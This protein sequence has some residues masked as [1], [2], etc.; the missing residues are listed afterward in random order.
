MIIKEE[1]NVK[2]MKN[3][4]VVANWNLTRDELRTLFISTDESDERVQ[5]VSGMEI[6][7]TKIKPKLVGGKS[8]AR[9][10]KNIRHLTASQRRKLA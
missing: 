3:G 1:F 4:K 6:R 10:P 7:I 8:L 5:F 9:L 2:S